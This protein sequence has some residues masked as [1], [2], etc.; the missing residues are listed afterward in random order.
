M[1][2]REL[3]SF[4][5]DG[6]NQLGEFTGTI[7]DELNLYSSLCL[8]EHNCS[9]PLSDISFSTEDIFPNVSLD[10]SGHPSFNIHVTASSANDE[11]SQLEY[12]ELLPSKNYSLKRAG[13]ED[14]RSCF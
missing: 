9:L 12:T 3:K 8:S 5:A 4:V 13:T 14:T 6:V 1:W 10:I 11:Q 2:K 7:A